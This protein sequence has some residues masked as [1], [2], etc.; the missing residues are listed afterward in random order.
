M[1]VRV[2]DTEKAAHIRTKPTIASTSKVKL[3]RRGTNPEAINDQLAPNPDDGT[4]N[5][6]FAG[7]EEPFFHWWPTKG[8]TEWVEYDFA[9][10]STVSAAEVFWLD[11]TGRGE[12]RVPESWRILYRQNG[13]WKPVEKPST[14]G[15]LLNRYNRATFT[16][17][18]TDALRLEIKLQP[19]WSTGIYEWKVE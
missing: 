11:D 5:V 13:E 3:S 17:V 7:N 14:Y 10:S 19:E 9:K 12:C 6:F 2:P 8:S 1:T 16:P 4:G 15:T 18:E